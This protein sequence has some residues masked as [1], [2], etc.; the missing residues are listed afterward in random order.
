MKSMLAEHSND[1]NMGDISN[2]A[3]CLGKNKSVKPKVLV[4]EDN[5]WIQKVTTMQLDELNC[6]HNVADSGESAIELCLQVKYDLILLDIGLPDIIGIDA[7]KMIR[8]HGKNTSTPI[9]A[10]TAFGKS[11]EK[12]C[13]DAG[14]N[15]Y[16][17]K[18]I[19]MDTIKGCIYRHVHQK[20]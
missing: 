15:E 13:R 2:V 1:H 3:D 19:L 18:P 17:V 7:C 14:V 8:A 4:V 12:S 11:V 5:Y 16:Y 9:V 10:V 6:L 20:K